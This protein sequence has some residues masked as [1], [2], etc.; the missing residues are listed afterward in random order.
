MMIMPIATIFV[1]IPSNRSP[2]SAVTC[3][4]RLKNRP[5]GS[6]EAVEQVPQGRSGR[7]PIAVQHQSGSAAP[8]RRRPPPEMPVSRT[9]SA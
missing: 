4:R 2:T 5:C 1:N 8:S 9:P 6:A 7:A 3:R